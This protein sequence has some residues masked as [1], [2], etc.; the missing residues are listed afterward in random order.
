M[1]RPSV[2]WSGILGFIL[3]SPGLAT[4]QTAITNVQH[5]PDPVSRYDK[6]E[7]TFDLGASYSNPYDTD[8][9][10]VRVEFVAPGIGSATIPAFW[11]EGYDRV[12]GGGTESYVYNGVDTWMARLMAR[13]VGTYQY[14]VLVNDTSGSATSEWYGF[15]CVASSAA[16]MIRVDD[17]NSRYLR[18]ENGD[19]YLP[20]GHN[21]CWSGGGGAY[22]VAGWLSQMEAVGENWARYWMVPYVGQGIEW[23]AGGYYSGLG[24]YSQQMASRFD[25]M[26]DAASDRGV[27][28]QFCM[29]S[30]N[31]WNYTVWHN[32]YDNPYSV[33]N[34]GMLSRPIDYLSDPTAKAYARKRF[35]YIV[36]RWAYSPAV[37]CWEFWN[38][39][40]IIGAGGAWEE[41]YHANRT[42]GAQWHQ[43]MAQ[44]LDALDPYDHLITTSFSND[45]D[46]L[47][48]PEIW[49][50]PEMD[51]VQCH[52]YTNSSPAEH[53]DLIFQGKAYPKPVILGEFGL[54]DVPYPSK[55]ATPEL[56][57]DP[58]GALL[59]SKPFGTALKIAYIDPTGQTLHDVIW[60]AAMVES[61]AMSW[62]WLEWIDPGNLYPVFAPLADFLE[63]EDWA[64]LGLGDLNYAILSGHGVDVYGSQSATHAFF[65]VQ[66]PLAG[67]VSGFQ[68]R[69]DGME[70]SPMDIEYWDTYA[71]SIVSSETVDTS[72]GSLTL[73]FPA[74]E[75]DLA[76]KVKVGASGVSTW[77]VY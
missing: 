36:A 58:G 32:W 35:R 67:T 27:A 11:Y 44:Y 22:R 53:I 33:A 1:K 60:P 71:G 59:M 5:Q 18:Y 64:P 15:S 63:G 7:I 47:R 52:R 73:D 29:D 24:R 30:F 23:K 21:I 54:G 65:W 43:E 51:I 17:R 50:L 76:V 45:P 26:V 28:V 46:P 25:G 3:L 48:F 12:Y 77:K 72:G 13:E 10:D 75:K 62:W 69:L 40:D 16:G 34:G 38:E 49:E 70:E 14:R 41:T 20:V 9:V 66:D 19:P 39:A 8:E 4:G 55:P 56:A 6:L 37:L 42:L 57:F 74:F 31:G 2:L 61:G 68:I